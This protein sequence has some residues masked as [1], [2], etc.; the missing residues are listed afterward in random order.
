VQNAIDTGGYLRAIEAGR[1]ATVKG[2]RLSSDDRVRGLI[3]ERLMCDLSI[4]LDLALRDSDAS[5]ASNFSSEIAAL[6]PLAASGV[7]EISGRRVTVTEAGRPFVRLIAAAF[8][9]Y[10]S[11]GAARHSMAV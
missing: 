10:R 7:I 3:I 4:D 5:P 11:N 8:D 2:I 1:F 6:K 9:S